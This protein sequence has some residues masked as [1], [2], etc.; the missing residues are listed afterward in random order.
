VKTLKGSGE[1]SIPLYDIRFSIRD[2]NERIESISLEPRSMA[3]V[4]VNANGRTRF[5]VPFL[6]GHQIVSL[7]LKK[8]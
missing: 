5:T 4:P 7:Q 2:P 1:N 3:I 8:R 6:Q